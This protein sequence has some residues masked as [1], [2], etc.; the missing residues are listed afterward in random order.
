MPRRTTISRSTLAGFR[1]NI[2]QFGLN[3]LLVRGTTRLYHIPSQPRSRNQSH[4]TS[5]EDLLSAI[6]RALESERAERERAIQAERVERDR[7]LEAERAKRDRALEAKQAQHRVEMVEVLAA[8]SQIMARFSQMESM[9]RGSVSV[10]TVT[11]NIAAPNK[12]SRPRVN[13]KSSVGSGSGN[14]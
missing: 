14:N 10:P 1:L 4:A 6:E 11:D 5:Q 9:W 3:I 13:V 7:L 2:L 12:N 8:Q